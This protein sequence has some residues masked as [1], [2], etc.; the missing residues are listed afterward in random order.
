MSLN[1][2]VVPPRAYTVGDTRSGPRSAPVPKLTKHTRVNMALC[3]L[4]DRFVVPLVR[5]PQAPWEAPPG[6]PPVG[7]GPPWVP[8]IERIIKTINSLIFFCIFF[9]TWIVL[10]LSLIS[11]NILIEI[12]LNLEV[13]P[14]RAYIVGGH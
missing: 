1:L 5:A 10:M 7:A 12:S 6:T 13:V 4:S 2:E 14:P 11:Y 8:R 9:S 3:A